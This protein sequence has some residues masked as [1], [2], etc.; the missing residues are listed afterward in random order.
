MAGQVRR[1][2]PRDDLRWMQPVLQGLSYW[3][4]YKTNAYW[5]YAWGESAIVGEL[6]TLMSAN[7]RDSRL[8]RAAWS[9]VLECPYERFG[10]QAPTGGPGRKQSA[11]I[12]VG[13]LDDKPWKNMGRRLA[14]PAFVFEVKRLSKE[15]DIK[16]DVLRLAKAISE[17][18]KANWAAFVIVALQGNEPPVGW[19]DR[20]KSKA[21]GNR[22]FFLDDDEMRAEY[23]VRMTAKT[24][25]STKRRARNWCC[26]LELRPAT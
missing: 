24:Y 23:K 7:I 12:V 26:L 13:K 5:Q 10:S 25:L 4:A 20:T 18:A 15:T 1:W 14:D 16:D 8:D 11:D 21:V 2:T 9:L 22:S 19:L 3:L 17:D 6:S